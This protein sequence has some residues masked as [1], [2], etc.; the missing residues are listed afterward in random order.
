MQE[1]SEMRE[2]YFAYLDEKEAVEK[3]LSEIFTRQMQER[4]DEF[5]DDAKELREKAEEDEF[6]GY[7]N[8]A[9]GQWKEYKDAV[10]DIE[11]KLDTYQ[12]RLE[13]AT[14]EKSIE[15]WEIYLDLY[16]QQLEIVQGKFDEADAN[17]QVAKYDKQV[18]EDQKIA[19][20]AQLAKEREYQEQLNRMNNGKELLD[21]IRAE[22]TAAETA[23]NTAVAEGRDGD[24]YQL[25]ED[26]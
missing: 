15:K 4:A 14:D 5:A 26:W 23:Y 16:G 2:E 20:A 3:R 6:M 7:Y 22:I 24:E 11:G 1:V 25:F 10:E 13:E 19:A 9:L 17:Y 21:E 12:E 18:R 8:E